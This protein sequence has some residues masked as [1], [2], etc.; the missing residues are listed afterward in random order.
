MTKIT[1]KL[2]IIWKNIPV[3]TATALVLVKLRTSVVFGYPY[4]KR[5]LSSLRLS[6]RRITGF[7]LLPHLSFYVI[8][9]NYRVFCNWLEHIGGSWDERSASQSA[10]KSGDDIGPLFTSGRDVTTDI[11][12]S[13]GT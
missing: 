12:E 8:I 1:N 6:D 4:D 3:L 13:R 7:V 2:V 5:L 11:T 9:P 10:E